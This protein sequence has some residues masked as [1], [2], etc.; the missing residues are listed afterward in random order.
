MNREEGRGVGVGWGWGLESTRDLRKST[1][2]LLIFVSQRVSG[3]W[4][5]HVSVCVCVCNMVIV[6]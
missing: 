5:A 4:C 1:D 2:Y 3:D 6:S